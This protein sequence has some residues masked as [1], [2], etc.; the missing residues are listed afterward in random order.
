MHSSYSNYLVMNNNNHGD[1]YLRV[2]YNF[3]Q[4]LL[5]DILASSLYLRSTARE[6]AESPVRGS[7]TS[8]LNPELGT[9]NCDNKGP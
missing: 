5:S 4:R 3:A 8:L 1:V 7:C 6:G 2:G 9:R